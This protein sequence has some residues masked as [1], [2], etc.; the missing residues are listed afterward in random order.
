MR[1]TNF[2]KK[3]SFATIRASQ[4]GKG[5]KKKKLDTCTWGGEEEDVSISI[6]DCSDSI[7][8]EICL[9]FE[10]HFSSLNNL[11]HTHKSPGISCMDISF[12]CSSTQWSQYT[13]RRV[14]KPAV[15]HLKKYLNKSIKV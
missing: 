8:E 15:L 14:K 5:I 10:R 7:H 2:N 12:R 4:M 6:S 9:H 1:E 13:M 3:G 11:P